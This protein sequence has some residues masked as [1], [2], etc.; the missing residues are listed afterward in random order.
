MEGRSTID[1][2]QRAMAL[3]D[4]EVGCFSLPPHE[5]R[6]DEIA[7]RVTRPQ[8]PRRKRRWRKCICP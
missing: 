4:H 5:G 1:D 7:D 3:G 8:V 2:E 6:M